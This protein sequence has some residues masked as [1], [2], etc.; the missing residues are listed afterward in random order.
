MRR[1]GL[2]TTGWSCLGSAHVRSRRPDQ[3]HEPSDLVARQADAAESKGIGE[4]RP[5]TLDGLSGRVLEIGA[6]SGLNFP[7]YPDAVEEIVAVEPE[8]Y[9]AELAEAKAGEVD[10]RVTV[11]RASAEALPFADGEFDAAVSF[12]VLCSVTDPAVAL[13]EIRRVLK[14][15]GQLRFNEHV[16][17]ADP[18]R[19]RWQRRLDALW[20]RIAGGCHL[21]RDT[22]ASILR[23]GFEVGD[24]ER[25][26]FGIPP[27]DPPKAH[28]LGRATSPAEV[29]TPVG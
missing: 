22:E 18:G 29:T 19:A 1:S 5:V 17:S 24:I 27:L 4:K 26:S 8:N 21:G 12:H 28:I 9:L 10:L 7:H 16:A 14:P 11:V 6:G 25:Y 20:P 13:S 23:A 3:T 2:P 15:G